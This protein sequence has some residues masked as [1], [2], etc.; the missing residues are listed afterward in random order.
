MSRRFLFTMVG[1]SMALGACADSTGPPA[2]LP[3]E[4]RQPGLHIIKWEPT[5]TP[6]LFRVIGDIPQVAEFPG[7]VALAAGDGGATSSVELWAVRGETRSVRIDYED[8]GGS[9]EFLEFTVTAG[10]LLQRPDGSLFAEGDSVLIT[11]SF[12]RERYLLEMQ[13]S[14]LV[15]SQ[16]EPALLQ[17]WYGGAD[18][19]LN[20]DGSVDSVDQYIEEDLLGV[21]YQEKGDEPWSAV[22]AAHSVDQKWFVANLFH[23][24]GYAVSW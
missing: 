24:S 4:S 12:D 3:D 1:A 16:V 20:G 10:A 17:V 21:W 19:D 13:P 9:G 22:T 23:F 15:F 6:R 2:E 7:G 8:D 14:G 11:I 5:Q 18:G